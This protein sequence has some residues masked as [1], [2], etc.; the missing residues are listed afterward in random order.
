MN[1]KSKKKQEKKL[2]GEKKKGGE[3]VESPRG[4]G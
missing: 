2:K 4:G 1:K 3:G